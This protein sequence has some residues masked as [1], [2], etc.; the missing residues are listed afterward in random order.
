MDCHHWCTFY[1][2]R[3]RFQNHSWAWPLQWNTS[4]SLEA[5]MAYKGITTTYDCSSYIS[6][7]NNASV[8][9]DI[10]VGHQSERPEYWQA[11][12]VF[13]AHWLPCG[14]PRVTCYTMFNEP[15]LPWIQSPLYLYFISAD[16]LFLNTYLNVFLFYIYCLTLY[17]TALLQMI[18][19]CA[20]TI[21]MKVSYLIHVVAEGYSQVIGW[22]QKR[23]CV[24]TGRFNNDCF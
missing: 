23:R 20:C 22:E 5:T 4:R 8:I 18:S 3:S 17:S 24:G 10:Y 13:P 14:L 12:H 16:I 15:A 7:S 9:S 2:S 6:W 19:D 11:S 21:T 1:Y